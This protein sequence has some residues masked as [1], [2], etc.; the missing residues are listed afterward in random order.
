VR[1]AFEH[2]ALHPGAHVLD[3]PVGTGRHAIWLAALGYQVTILDIDP[4]LVSTTR[5]LIDPPGNLCEAVVRD[6]CLRLPFAD[7]RFS[8]VL[9]V[10]FVEEKLLRQVGR[11]IKP[12]GWLVYES[13]ASRGENW[14][15]LLPPGK[16]VSI[17]SD[18]FEIVADKANAA[19]PTKTEAESIK[20]WARRR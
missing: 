5:E 15:Q 11:I 18:E 9:I 7:S 20:L 13:Y 3:I 10:D 6:A 1:R 14:R 4:A 2:I 19:G 16:T 8:A 12:D 17:L